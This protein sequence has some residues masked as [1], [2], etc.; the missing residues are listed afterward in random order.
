MAGTS[1]KMSSILLYGLLVLFLGPLDV[2]AGDADYCDSSS[3]RLGLNPHVF[4][5]MMII[6]AIFVIWIP[7]T[8]YSV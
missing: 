7:S 2:L 6:V 5:V 3:S 4:A 1:F 8:T